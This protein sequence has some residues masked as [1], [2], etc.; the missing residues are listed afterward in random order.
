MQLRIK[1]MI[2]SERPRERLLKYGHESLSNAELIGLILRTGTHKE[3]AVT[4]A[5]RLLKKFPLNELGAK[6]L[7][8]FQEIKG[9]GLAKACQLIAA[10]ELGRRCSSPTWHDKISIKSSR[11]AI[12]ILAP[13][14]EDLDKEHF[15]ILLLDT[16][17]NLIK[18]ERIFIGT[19]DNSVIHPREIF[20][21]AIIESSS[22]II[23]AHNHPSGDP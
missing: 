14:M 17:H 1:D 15:I 9:I 6:R 22:A 13:E 20:K 8:Q 23:I 16:R 18:K 19:L 4:L 10:F 7:S 21:P 3:N 11:D 12:N 5:N 2:A